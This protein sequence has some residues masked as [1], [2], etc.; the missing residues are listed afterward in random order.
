MEVSLSTVDRG[1]R[2]NRWP[3]NKFIRVGIRKLYYSVT[4][5]DE[6]INNFKNNVNGQ[7]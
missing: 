3:Y 6:I 5:K 4:L 1:I 2:D 7:K